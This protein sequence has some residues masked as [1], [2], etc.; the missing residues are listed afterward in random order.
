MPARAFDLIAVGSAVI[1]H[2]HRVTVLPKRDA[3]VMILDR[4]SGPGGVEGN[5]AASAAR[6][7]LRVGV[8]CRL[9]CDRDGTMVL[10]DFR[11]RG[12]DVSRVQVGG[13]EETAYTLIFVDGQGDRIMMTGGHGVRGL[14]LDE[15]DDAYI[16]QARVCFASGYLPAPFLKRVADIC[17]G[18]GGPA[19]AFDLPGEF[20]DLEARGLRPEQ[21][22]AL[23]PGIDLFLTNRDSLRSYTGEPSIDSGLAHLRAK[24]VRR[25]SVSD[26]GRGLYLMDALAVQPEIHHVPGFSV[27]AVDTTGAGDV[28]S[29]ALIAALLLD[30]QPTLAAGRFAAAAAALSCQGWGVRVALPTRAEAEAMTRK[31]FS[32]PE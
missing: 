19:F 11:A 12:V 2:I 25:A 8:I 20:D 7:G 13:E 10:D 6:L 1:D 17:A 3:G 5:V 14:T 23:L 26:G 22:D 24:G 32:C 18:H 27:R 29:A 30:N 4:Q 31:E 9:G 15:A 28:L 16:R 21:L